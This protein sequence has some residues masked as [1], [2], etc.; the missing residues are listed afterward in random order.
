MVVF[1]Q[2]T[3]CKHLL[4]EKKNDH[5]CCK[6]FPDGIPEDVFWNRVSHNTVIEGD[7]GFKFEPIKDG[8]TR[9]LELG[10]WNGKLV[11]VDDDV[12]TQEG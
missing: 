4:N 11:V 12:P 7:H 3:D 9:D 5:F 1:P 10:T 2:C 8:I 6:A